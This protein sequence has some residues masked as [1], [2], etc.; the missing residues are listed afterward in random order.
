MQDKQ[1]LQQ[2]KSRWAEA[3]GIEPHRWIGRGILERSLELKMREQ[4]AQGL[5]P[6]QKH[7][8]NKLVSAYKRNPHYFDQGHSILKPGMRLVREWQGQKHIV[9]V[10]QTGFSY[11]NNDYASL[12]TVANKITGSRWNG[13]VFFGLKNKKG[14]A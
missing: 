8:L 10:T 3:W 9:T 4:D 5:A 1:S 12:S 13:W 14:A 6:E 7:R 11:Q 2:L